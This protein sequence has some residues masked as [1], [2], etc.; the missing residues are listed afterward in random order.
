MGKNLLLAVM[1]TVILKVGAPPVLL[2][3]RSMVNSPSCSS[4]SRITE[5]FWPP[6]VSPFTKKLD[7]SLPT[8][9]PTSAGV[10][11]MKV[12]PGTVAQTEGESL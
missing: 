1:V 5:H 9:I 3:R 6:S 4:E 10:M 8:R 2:V 12:L 7:R 11:L